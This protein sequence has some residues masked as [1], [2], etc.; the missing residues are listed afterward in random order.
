MNILLQHKKNKTIVLMKPKIREEL[1]KNYTAIKSI[2]HLTGLNDVRFGVLNNFDAKG[3]E[4]DSQNSMTTNDS[5]EE[6]EEEAMDVSDDETLGNLNPV[7]DD[8]DSAAQ[9]ISLRSRST[10]L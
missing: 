2:M 10:I 6:Q 5:D 8:E 1:A 7:N 3:K 9:N 4:I